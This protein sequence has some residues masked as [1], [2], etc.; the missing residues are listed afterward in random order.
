MIIPSKHN[1]YV[2]CIRTCFK[3]GGS[4]KAYKL[5][6]QQQQKME[7]AIAAINNIFDNAD[8][9]SLYD[10][11]QQAVYNLNKNTLDDNYNDAERTNRFALARNGLTGG[12]ADVDSQADLQERYA[13]GLVEAEG[14]GQTAASDLQQSDETAKSNLI[15]LAEAGL[16]SGSA[17]NQATSSLNSNYQSSLGDRSASTISN[18]FNDMGQLYLANKIANATNNAYQNAYYDN[19]SNKALQT[20][21]N[22]YQGS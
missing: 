18:Y 16:D 10:E 11:Q 21:S 2:D 4:N 8:R 15:S 19:T 9:Q 17:A 12:S 14:L 1:G 5:Q 13:K 7:A 3:G 20:K 6:K 22:N